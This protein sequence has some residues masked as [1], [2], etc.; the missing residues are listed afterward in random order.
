M[1]FSAP[2]QPLRQAAEAKGKLIGAAI[3]AGNLA[4]PMYQQVAGTEFNY[5]TPENDTKWENTEPGPGRFTFANGDKVVAFAKDHGMKVR[6]HT[7]LWHLALPGWVKELD[8]VELKAAMLRH[9][10]GVMEHYKGQMYAWDVLN[11]AIADGG[12][13]EHRTGSPFY[14]KLGIEYVALA[15]RAA[16]EI[17]PSAKLFYND[18]GAEISG[19]PK[20]EAVYRLVKSLVDQG[21]PISGVGLQM[22][23]SP[24]Q[25]PPIKL[26]RDTMQRYADLDLLVNI[27]E[28]DLPVGPIRGTLDEKLEQ[29]AKAYQD[30]VSVCVTMTACDAVSFWGFTDKYT[31]LN[32][33]QYAKIHGR[34][35]HLP[36]LYTDTFVPKPARQ[37][38]LNAF[39]AP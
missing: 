9:I 2:A 20:T 23:V 24:R 11:E 19:W 26:I 6:G 36:L 21:V 4:D 10:T 5:L 7:L 34:G 31:W 13:G 14:D 37:A 16:H 12:I 3:A 22:H 27:S 17:D 33:P 8:D 30:I 39:V 35:P 38:V 29:Q 1:I 25:L 32:L 28:M 18:Y 15:F